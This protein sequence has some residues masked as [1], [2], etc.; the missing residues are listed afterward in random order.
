MSKEDLK[1]NPDMF[2]IDKKSKKITIVE[3]S[4][5]T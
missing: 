5:V 2:I 3:F 1:K 4:G